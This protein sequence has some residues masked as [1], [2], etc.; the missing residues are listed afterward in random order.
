MEDVTA[1]FVYCRLHG[2]EELYVSGYTDSALDWWANRLRSWRCGS[3]PEDA[4]RVGEASKR[5]CKNRD[6]YVYFD[7]DA[8][9]KAPFDAM[10]LEAR[11]SGKEL[12]PLPEALKD[13]GEP[14]REHWPAMRRK[15][16]SKR[17]RTEAY[18]DD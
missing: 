17:R 4:K 7:N 15:P 10:N 12:V 16:P 5:K 9:V 6:V 3:E 14:A 8:K 11:L 2:D 1:D 13:A 18:R